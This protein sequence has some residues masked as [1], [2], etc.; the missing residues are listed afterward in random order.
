MSGLYF[1][2]EVDYYKNMPEVVLVRHAQS[3]ANERDFAA[4]G[5]CDSPLTEKGRRQAYGLRPILTSILG[6]S[7]ILYDKPVVSSEFERPLETAEIAGFTRI[8]RSPLINESEVDHYI[9][10]G[11]NVVNK[12]MTERWVPDESKQRARQLIEQVRSGELEYEV[13]F[14]HGIFIAAILLEL[15]SDGSVTDHIFDEERGYAPLQAGVV[16]V[17]I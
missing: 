6:A 8:H 5:N 9:A 14:T 1:L 17:N 2:D 3:K 16:Q 15:N 12:H 10:N 4:F 7:P 11:I 13:Y